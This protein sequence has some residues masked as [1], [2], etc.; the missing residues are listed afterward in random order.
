MKKIKSLSEEKLNEI[1]A[2]VGESFWEYPYEY[3]EGGLRSLI[4]SRQAM[5]DY[6]KA[7]IIAGIESGTFYSTNG[8]EGYILLT[9]SYGNHPKFTSIMKMMINI[10]KALG[11]WGKFSEFMKTASSGSETLEQSMKK[12][13]RNFVKVEMLIVTRD[14]QG[15]GYMRKLMNFAYLTAYRKNCSLILDTDAKS[16]C[17]RYIHLGMKLERIRQSA[18][19]P[20]YDLIREASDIKIKNKS[21][22]K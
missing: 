9:D 11:G 13:K 10:K 8:G 14:Y 22:N 18:G 3:G 17:D 16:K 20:I 7:L 1:S 15:K 19:F 2:L 12:Q 6:M 21:I 5:D 4:P